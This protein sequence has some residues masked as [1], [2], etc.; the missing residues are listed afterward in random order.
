MIIET[1]DLCVRLGARDILKGINLKVSRAE[2]FV[3]LGPSGSG[4][5]VLL[6]TFL[7]LIRSFSGKLRVLGHDMFRIKY[8]ELLQL[9][10]KIGMVFQNAAL[11]DSMKVWENVGFSFL[12]HSNLPEEEIRVKTRRVLEAVGLFDVLDKMPEEL[13][14]GMRK[15]VGIARALIGEPEVLFYD[16]PTAGLDVVTSSSI[17]NLMK[18]IHSQF[19]TTD[20][21]VTHDLTIARDFADKI[22]IIN[23]GKILATGRWDDLLKSN[24]EFIKTMLHHIERKGR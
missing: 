7:G 20:I 13:S 10:R 22:A 4:K 8:K 19:N 17:L 21:I 12:E 24:D 9:R 3:I 2:Y 14:G 1:E 6:K 23:E 15:R 18:N 11:F 5:T 16:E